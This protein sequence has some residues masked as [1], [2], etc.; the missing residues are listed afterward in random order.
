MNKER[1]EKLNKLGIMGKEIASISAKLDK[2]LA[3]MPKKKRA[4]KK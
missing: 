2:I 3:L 1:L 4:V